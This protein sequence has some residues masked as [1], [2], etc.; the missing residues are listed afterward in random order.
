MESGSLGLCQILYGM[1]KY[2]AKKE[3]PGRVRVLS[4]TYDEY[5]VSIALQQKSP[6]RKP[7]N[8]ALLKFMKTQIWAELTNRYLQ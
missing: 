2:Q 7:I 5:F 4:E 1:L 6:L 3:F 8:K